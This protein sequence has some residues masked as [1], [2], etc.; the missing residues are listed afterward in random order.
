MIFKKSSSIPENREVDLVTNPSYSTTKVPSSSTPENREVAPVTNSSYA[1]TKV[2]SSSTPENREVDLVNNSFYSTTKDL[3]SSTPENREVDFVNNPSYSTIKVPSTSTPYANA[4]DPHFYEDASMI[5]YTAKTESKCSTSK[6]STVTKN[7]EDNVYEDV[8]SAVYKVGKTKFK[9][10][11]SIKLK[12]MM[13]TVITLFVILS[14]LFL[15]PVI[16]AKNYQ[17]SNIPIL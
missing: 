1:T 11:I 7:T 13:A 12:F 10:S 17:V 14:A 5:T 4:E 6:P 2:C 8:S 16:F 15:F 3:S 9:I